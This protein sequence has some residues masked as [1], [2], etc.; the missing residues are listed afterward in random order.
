MRFGVPNVRKTMESTHFNSLLLLYLIEPVA[1]R[2]ETSKRIR[3]K[4]TQI[5]ILN[6]LYQLNKNTISG[7]WTAIAPGKNL[8]AKAAQ[9]SSDS[10]QSFINSPDFLLFGE[11]QERFQ[12]TNIYKLHPWV[13]QLF[14][15]FEVKGMMKNI[16]TDFKSW[17]STFAK[18]MKK[19]LLPLLEKGVTIKDILA[20]R[21]STKKT[22]NS[23]PPPPLKHPPMKPLPGGDEA[24]MVTMVKDNGALEVLDR[25]KNKPFSLDQKLKLSLFPEN[26]YHTAKEICQIKSAKGFMAKDPLAYFLGIVTK[27]AK[28]QGFTPNWKQ[29][30]ASR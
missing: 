21:L 26:I 12:A 7:K 18:R 30:Y 2:T 1:P 9:V 20:Q 29:Y 4:P 19:W 16:Q 5:K 13:V 22:L 23:T 24:P 17:R 10:V 28:D 6:A 27:L 15:F 11:K 8:I 3:S 14:K 25:L